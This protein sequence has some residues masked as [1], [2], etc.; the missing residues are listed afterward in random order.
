VLVIAGIATVTAGFFG[1]HSV[2][3]AWVGVRATKARAQAS[4]LYFFSFY[5]GSSVAGSLG[6]VFWQRWGWPGLIGFL[7]GMI[8]VSFGMLAI[9]E[10]EAVT[11]RTVIRELGAGH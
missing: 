4:G 9:L 5:I 3:S 6:G 1:A 7:V 2:A 10:R 8:G 11:P